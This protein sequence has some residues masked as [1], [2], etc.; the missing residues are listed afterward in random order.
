M[1]HE[2]SQPCHPFSGLPAS[3]SLALESFSNS[4]EGPKVLSCLKPLFPVIFLCPFV[5][6]NVSQPSLFLQSFFK[7]PSCSLS[8]LPHHEWTRP[9]LLI[10]NKCVVLGPIHFQQRFL[11]IA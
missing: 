6:S 3:V 4:K 11:E 9:L 10:G 2:T 5:F 1:E 8:P 7:S